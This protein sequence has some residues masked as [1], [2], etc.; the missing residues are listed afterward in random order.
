MMGSFYATIENNSATT[1]FRQKMT[2]KTEKK[3]RP[4][5]GDEVL[6]LT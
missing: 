5:K 6:N 1:S 4:I 3:R 2:V